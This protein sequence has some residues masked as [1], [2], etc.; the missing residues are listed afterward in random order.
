MSTGTSYILLLMDH[1]VKNATSMEMS[2]SELDETKPNSI[3]IT[4]IN[5]KQT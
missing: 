5:I 4:N 3:Q 2:L 1:Q